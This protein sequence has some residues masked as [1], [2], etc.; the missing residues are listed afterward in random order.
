[1]TTKQSKL[2][3]E[4]LENAKELGM[5]QVSDFEFQ[6]FMNT[7]FK[8][9]LSASADNHIAILKTA[10]EQALTQRDFHIEKFNQVINQ[11]LNSDSVNYDM[12]IEMQKINETLLSQNKKMMDYLIKLTRDKTYPSAEF[13][14][15]LFNS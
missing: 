9:D 6:L 7:D 12:M 3:T 11:A 4:L 10:L 14:N 8:V 15:R 13:I 1:M 5:I 2:S